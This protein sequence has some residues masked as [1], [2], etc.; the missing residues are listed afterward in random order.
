MTSKTKKEKERGVNGR[1]KR[2]KEGRGKEGKIY[3][4]KVPVIA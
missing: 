1:V 2:R 3:R 4:K